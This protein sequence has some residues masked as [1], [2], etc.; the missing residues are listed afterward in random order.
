MLL[1]QLRVNLHLPVIERVFLRLLL[2]DQKH[3][4]REKNGGEISLDLILMPPS[5]DDIFGNP[6]LFPQIAD[7]G[8]QYGTA[9]NPRPIFHLGRR[10]RREGRRQVGRR[11]GASRQADRQQK[12]AKPI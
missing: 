3:R 10:R 12:M 4:G 9:L 5:R 8:L 1:R 7:F 11:P 2:I 6:Y